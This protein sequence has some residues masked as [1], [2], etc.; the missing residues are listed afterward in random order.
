MHPTLTNAV[1]YLCASSLLL[2]LQFLGFNLLHGSPLRTPG[3][4]AYAVGRR[5]PLT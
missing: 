1:G 3:S 5:I 2:P 4:S